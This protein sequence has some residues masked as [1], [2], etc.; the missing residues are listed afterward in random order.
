MKI[1][2][3]VY[4]S[5]TFIGMYWLIIPKILEMNPLL[6]HITYQ[7]CP[8]SLPGQSVLDFCGLPSGKP[9]KNYGKSPCSQWVNHG[10]STISM[11]MF[12]SYFDITRGYIC[13]HYIPNRGLCRLQLPG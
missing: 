13:D 12:N 1:I 3:I 9:T 7:E 8:V 6:C 11:V 5:L 4:L 2:G 10:K